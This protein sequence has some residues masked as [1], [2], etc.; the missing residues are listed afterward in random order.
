MIPG[1]EGAVTAV[2]EAALARAFDVAI[3]GLP[4]KSSVRERGRIG[5]AFV[6]VSGAISGFT[7]FI[8]FVPDAFF[9]TLAIMR[10]VAQ[11]AVEEGENLDDPDTKLACLA[12]FGSS[13]S[14]PGAQ[15]KQPDISYFLTRSALH[16]RPLTLLLSEVARRYGVSLSQKFVLQA[17]PLLG[18]AGGAGLNI[19]YM[20]HYRR[21]ARAVFTIRRLQQK[22]EFVTAAA[23]K[24]VNDDLT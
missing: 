24:T 6:G 13:P 3:L 15:G 12:V 14:D 22:D 19:A 17:V 7:G 20:A 21:V 23:L 2:A 4:L 1:L 16:G 9:T 8:G 10:S 11:V 18:A 5:S